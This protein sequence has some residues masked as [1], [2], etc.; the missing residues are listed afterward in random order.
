[1]EEEGNDK[2]E[3][4][5]TALHLAKG[6]GKTTYQVMPSKQEILDRLA[7]VTSEE[8]EF[9]PAIM[10]VH[11]VLYTAHSS[12]GVMRIDGRPQKAPL[13]EGLRLVVELLQYDDSLGLW[14]CLEIKLWRSSQRR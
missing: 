7:W 9:D 13:K 10:A 1:V 3:G 2:S 5:G 8:G 12:D 14:C 4:D 6:D 11:L